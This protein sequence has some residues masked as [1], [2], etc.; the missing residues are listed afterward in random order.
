MVDGGRT[1]SL[2]RSTG[3]RPTQPPSLIGCTDE[4]SARR[5]RYRRRGRDLPPE[6]LGGA[7]WLS[8]ASARTGNRCRRRT[9]PRGTAGRPEQAGYRDAFLSVVAAGADDGA[10]GTKAPGAAEQVDDRVGAVSGAVP[11]RRGRQPP[12]SPDGDPSRDEGPAAAGRGPIM[13]SGG[14][15]FLGGPKH[16]R[17]IVTRTRTMHDLGPL[18]GRACARQATVPNTTQPRWRRPVAGRRRHRHPRAGRRR[19]GVMIRDQRRNRTASRRA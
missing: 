2:G 17:A 15:E 14:Q 7:G 1:G 11:A 5:R 12:S 3:D 6:V 19:L 10:A 8:P 13:W 18:L 16:S 9:S 4:G